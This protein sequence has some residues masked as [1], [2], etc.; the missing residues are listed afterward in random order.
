M[1]WCCKRLWLWHNSEPLSSDLGL[2]ICCLSFW[3]EFFKVTLFF[4]DFSQ[5]VYSLFRYTEF[6]KVSSQREVIFTMTSLSAS[7]LFCRWIQECPNTLLPLNA[8]SQLCF[9]AHGAMWRYSLWRGRKIHNIIRLE[10]TLKHWRFLGNKKKKCM[11]VYQV[12][13]ELFI[14][15]ALLSVCS[16]SLLLL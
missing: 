13:A 15:T 10:P 9:L 16:C 12:D 4:L 2:W 8:W 7:D 11:I 5:H 6:Q 14:T 3:V 1:I